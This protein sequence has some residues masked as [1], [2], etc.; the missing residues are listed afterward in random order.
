MSTATA[1]P[2]SH[3]TAIQE[4]FENEVLPKV[5]EKF[6]ITNPMALPRIDK[7][8]INTGMGKQ[9]ENNKLKPEIRDT[10]LS[11]LSTVSGQKAVLIL[12]RKSV[13]NFKVREGATASAMVTLRRDRMWSLLSRLIHLAIPRVKDFRGL[14]DTSFDKQGNY[15]FGFSEQAVFPEIDMGKVNF[16]HGMHINISFRNSTP[17]ISRFVLAELGWPFKRE[18]S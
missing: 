3:K 16:N 9:L 1:A 10:I 6:G 2:T 14:K 12:S 13:A 4:K 15:S 11:T 5:K 17:A 8:V 18:E 7:V